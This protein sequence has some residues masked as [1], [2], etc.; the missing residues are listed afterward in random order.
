MTAGQNMRARVSRCSA[1]ELLDTLSLSVMVDN[2]QSQI[3]DVNLT[4]RDFINIVK[5]K[6]DI[7]KD[8]D[9][10]SETMSQ[11][12][13]EIN[14]FYNKVVNQLIDK[15]SLMYSSSDDLGEVAEVMYEFFTVQRKHN[16]EKF[17]E[18]Y[19]D[20]HMDEIAEALGLRKLND[21]MTMNYVRKVGDTDAARIAANINN[22]IEHILSLGISSDEFLDVLSGEGDYYVSKM[23]D[24]KDACEIDGDYPTLYMEEIL[25]EYD[26]DYASQVRNSLRC[27]FGIGQ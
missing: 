1:D 4:G 22:V 7:I 25:N 17:L 12:N 24:Y 20:E 11:I 8:G 14:T 9:F 23:Q 18:A 21:V 27:R 5:N 3:D 19:I 10:D 2:I 15:F 16:T 13:D 26:S 6:F